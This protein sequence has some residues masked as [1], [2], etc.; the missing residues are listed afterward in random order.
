MCKYEKIHLTILY[1]SVALFIISLTSIYLYGMTLHEWSCV[2]PGGDHP[3]FVKGTHY[4]AKAAKE[5]NDLGHPTCESASGSL[6]S[7]LKSWGRRGPGLT[8]NLDNLRMS[9]GTTLASLAIVRAVGWRWPATFVDWMMGWPLQWSALRPLGT[10]IEPT[11]SIKQAS[12][13]QDEF[14]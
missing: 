6:P 3:V 2:F 14:G 12:R 5:W 4:T 8:N 10:T 7:P 9:L 13:P 1:T 11:R